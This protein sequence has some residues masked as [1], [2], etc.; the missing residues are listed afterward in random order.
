MNKK[1][2]K[3][4]TRGKGVKLKNTQ[5]EDLDDIYDFQ[6]KDESQTKTFRR[7]YDRGRFSQKSNL[8]LVEGRIVLMQTNYSYVVNINGVLS[9]CTL[10]GRLRYL[11]FES[12]NPVCVGDY[13]MIDM[14][15]KDNYRIEEIKPR[16]NSLSRYVSS[17]NMER[18]IAIVAN[19]DQI[20]IVV[21]CNNPFFNSGL[22]DRYLCLAEIS[23]INAAICVNKVDLAEDLDAIKEEC[24]Y[25]EINGY[26]VVFTTANKEQE[27]FGIEELKSMLKNKDSVFTG[28]SGTGKSS[29]INAIEPSLQLK[30]GDVSLTHHKGQH[31]TSHSEMI[32]WSFG[33]HLIDTPGIKTLAL[34]AEHKNLLPMNF[35]G[36]AHYAQF[37]FFPDCSHTHEEHCAVLDHV[38]TEIPTERYESYLRIVE[39]L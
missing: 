9:N 31:T 12:H 7:T 24:K 28:H 20:I 38:G 35:P 22:I 29:L 30:V 17:A 14:Q 37:C 16:R 1:R 23:Q 8:D 27:N 32:D 6:E 10:S 18:E 39:S 2:D 33:G 21:S 15:E 25:Y 36:F 26:Q 3:F 13:V 5:V 4:V 19:I 34:S 11:E